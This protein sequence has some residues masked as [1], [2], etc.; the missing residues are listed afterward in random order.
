L[1]GIFMLVLSKVLKVHVFV[2]CQ[3]C[4]IWNQPESY[5]TLWLNQHI[6]TVLWM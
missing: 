6:V 4:R 3:I 1:I 5:F 2:T